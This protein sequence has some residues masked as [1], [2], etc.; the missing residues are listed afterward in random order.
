MASN[1]LTDETPRG[2]RTIVVI[3]RKGGAG[4]ST[5]I[6][7][8]A[9][10]AAARGESV[11]VID[12]D[13]SRS[14]HLW[15]EEATAKGL[16]ADNIKAV[17]TTSLDQVIETIEKAARYQD[18]EHLI[19]IDT[20]G[21]ASPAYAD[22]LTIADFAIAP[23]IPDKDNFAETTETLAWYRRLADKLAA[24]GD[25]A[26][27]LMVML[28]MIQRQALQSATEQ[29]FIERAFETM[30]MLSSFLGE[31][32]AYKEMTANGLLHKIAEGK[33][34]KALA[35]HVKRA[36]IEATDLLN[37][38]DAT[39]MGLVLPEPQAEALETTHG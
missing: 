36:L 10:A 27:P 3:N 23:L 15:M 14:N 21:G 38:I 9:S 12:T 29:H 6:K 19:L 11:T 34:T 31:R 30:N 20:F 22:I 17:P 16:W 35:S 4:K 2:V 1:E 5:T 25:R 13:V 7:A 24:Q 8:L 37:D 32:A 18:Q 26:A 33:S 28:N 39:R